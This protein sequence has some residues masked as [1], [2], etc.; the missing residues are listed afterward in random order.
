MI[1]H[2]IEN[3]IRLN[4]S[5]NNQKQISEVEQS[6]RHMASESRVRRR[7]LAGAL[8][9]LLKKNPK[10]NRATRL[11]CSKDC[12]EKAYLFLILPFIEGTEYEEYLGVRRNLLSAYCEVAKLKCPEAS[13][14]IGYATEPVESQK[15]S[16][17]LLTL[18][19]QDWTPVRQQEAERLQKKYGLL[20]DENT[21]KT[22]TRTIEWP[23]VKKVS[24]DTH[25]DSKL[26]RKIRKK[27]KLKLTRQR[28]KNSKESKRKNRRQKKK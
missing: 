11:V 17:D 8:V 15:N 14:I 25:Q 2:F 23:E 26:N 16:E 12:P 5:G 3:G 20:L 22:E 27:S 21:K 6:L 7:H 1:E 13:Y 24:V 9:D 10:D 28:R 18:N 4:L 19:V